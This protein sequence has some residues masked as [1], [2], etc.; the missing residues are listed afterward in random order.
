MSFV[1]R[2]TLAALAFAAVGVAQ[3]SEI[4]EFPL[5]KSSASRADVQ[6]QA[7]DARTQPGELYDG[8]LL[9][10]AQPTMARETMRD[11]ARITDASRRTDYL[12][13]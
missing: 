5:E 10:R 3:A 4:T 9:E 7:R 12:G 8:R 11:A 6:T 2:T 13:G 1:F